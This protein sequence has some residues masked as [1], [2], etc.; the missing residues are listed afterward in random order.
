MF[1]LPPRCTRTDPL[2]PYPTLFRS[3]DRSRLAPMSLA[4]ENTLLRSAA[5]ASLRS[6]RF[7]EGSE[8]LA[9]TQDART[10]GLG[11]SK[12]IGV[13]R[14]GISNIGWTMRKLVDCGACHLVRQS[15]LY[16]LGG[17]AAEAQRSEE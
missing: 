2:F 8:F 4:I 11:R 12:D 3:P 9:G 6:I 10:A 5:A 17:D 7:Q 14:V 15:Q 13:F 1:R 16:G